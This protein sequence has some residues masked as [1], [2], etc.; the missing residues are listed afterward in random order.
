MHPTAPSWL[1]SDEIKAE[2]WATHLAPEGAT[3]PCKGAH[4]LFIDNFVKKH[5][6]VRRRGGG[7]GGRGEAV[8]Q[9]L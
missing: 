2:H 9:G 6:K 1:Q 4:M 7:S 3:G 8:A 5:G